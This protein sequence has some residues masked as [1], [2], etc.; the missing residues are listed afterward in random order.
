[1]KVKNIFFLICIVLIF[2]NTVLK[3]NIENKIVI[4]VGDKIIT[5]YEVKNKILTNLILSNLEIT[6]SNIDSYKLRAHDSLIN[7]KLKEIELRNKNIIVKEDEI[8][9]YLNSLFPN[10]LVEFKN[11]FKINNLDLEY[12]LN[13]LKTELKWRKF[14]YKTY[15]KRI[16]FDDISIERDIK[17]F[18]AKKKK[19][20]EYK[21]SEIEILNNENS[22][23]NIEEVKNEI[24]K[25]GFEA[26]AVKYSISSSAAKKGDIGWIKSTSLS[27]QIYEILSTLNINQ[28]SG[29]ILRSNSIVF[30]KLVNKKNV[31]NQEIDIEKIKS[32]FINVKRNEIFSLYSSSHLS[33]L[34]NQTLI[35]YSNE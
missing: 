22:K 2:N 30:L 8:N 23:K 33:K 9:S 16:S 25:N 35:Q 29:P 1:M 7:F 19:I 18:L 34:K 14:I 4:K 26:A 32:N 13:E 10:K 12:Y 24:K 15:Q 3:A 6:Q 20:D 31:S 11:I 21:I 28:I 27:K 17:E 5:S